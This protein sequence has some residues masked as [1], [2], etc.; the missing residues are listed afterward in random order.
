MDLLQLLF[1]G[2]A[3]T[4][5]ITLHEYAHAIVAYKLGDP[6]PKLQG[7]LTLDPRKHFDPIGA[8]MIVY[9]SLSGIGFG[10]GKP[11]IINPYNFKK[12]QTDELIVAMAGPA[13]NFLIAAIAAFCI[14]F[15]NIPWERFNGFL[16]LLI[17]LNIGLM[18]FNLIPIP[19]LDGSKIFAVLFPITWGN[20]RMNFERYGGMVLLFVIFFAKGILW[21][22]LSPLYK[23]LMFVLG[24]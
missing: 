24:F 16:L 21:W 3:I 9:A 20:H 19:P 17:Q 10:W 22:I 23:M 13:M 5:A 18:L 14:H 7:R 15:M 4:T 12:P 11:V 2:I 1:L 6:T 8:M